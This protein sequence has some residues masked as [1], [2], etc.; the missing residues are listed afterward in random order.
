MAL[1]ATIAWL[2]V[3]R[4]AGWQPQVV[5]SGSMEPA[6]PVGSVAFVDRRDAAEVRIGDILTFRHPDYPRRLVS[7]RVVAIDRDARGALSFRTKGDANDSAD[8]WI[9]S[10]D[11]VVG[12]VAFH[13]PYAGY[14]HRFVRTPAGF[15]LVVGVP[16][17]L[18]VAGEVGNIARQVRRL[19]GVPQP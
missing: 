17:L 10:A 16:A 8:P 19:K 1:L 12:V 18:V 9:V 7:H 2:T 4:L 11:Q 14:V 5:L 3:P 6:L 13:L 15:A